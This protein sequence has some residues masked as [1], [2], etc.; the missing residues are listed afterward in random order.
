[1]LM[2]LE[3]N[4]HS[5]AKTQNMKYV[6]LISS[7][8]LLSY[9]LI[10][11]VS[12]NKFVESKV[13]S[14]GI[15]GMKTLDT[16]VII[17]EIDVGVVLKKWQSEKISK[18]AEP[19]IVDISPFEQGLWETNGNQRIN[20]IKITAKKAN[21]I[22]VYFDKLKLSN[23]AELYI[24]NLDG[25]VI[26]GP[27]T[28]KE[29]IEKNILWGSNVFGGSTIILEFKT[30]IAEEKSN[31]LHIRK[32]LYGINPK[33]S[34][35]NKDSIMGPGFGL[36]SSC[37]I[38]V[39]CIPG[40]EQERR[41][42]AQVV[43]EGGG[44]CSAALIMNTCNTNRPY[45]LTANHCIFQN[46][47]L[48]NTNNSTFEFLWFSSACT[49]TTNTTSTLLFNGAVIRAR[50]EQS[51][52]ALLELNQTIPTNANLTLLGWSRSTTPPSSSVGIHHPLGDIMKISIENNPA[53]IGNVRTFANTA[54]RVVWDQG[55]AEGGSSGSPLFDINHRVVGQLFSNTQPSSPP[56]N[57]PTGGT[58]YG[59]FDI[60][61]AGGGTNSTR[62]SNWLDPS[63]SGVMTTNTTNVSAL[64]QSIGDLGMSIF[65]PDYLCSSA[66]YKLHGVPVGSPVTWSVSNPNIATVTPSGYVTATWGGG[67]FILSASTNDNCGTPINVT[68][69]ISIGAPN[70]S[71]YK[72]IGAGTVYADAG[73][74]YSVS[75]LGVPSPVNITWIVPAGWTIMNGQGTENITI[76]TGST[77]GSVTILFDNVCGQQTGTYKTVVIGTGGPAPLSTDPSI[78]TL[79]VTPNPASSNVTVSLVT[80]TTK[81]NSGANAVITEIKIIDKMGSVRKRFAFNNRSASQLI[82]I[83]GLSLDTY[84][85]QAF[86]GTKWLSAKLLIVNN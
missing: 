66:I 71:S 70:I 42:V 54:W 7:Y 80:N 58:N 59:R 53:S 81:M 11:Q 79:A 49:P 35:S 39:T 55:T 29:N 3:L 26:T 40:W 72:V 13:S 60:S 21:S 16:E 43:D 64:F 50:W 74:Y 18:F 67:I 23:N 78:T 20:R 86:T 5:H 45:I 56:C 51:D 8:L 62:L 61:W 44:W 33:L 73:Y 1:M 27:I 30:P 2:A 10:A 34:F 32:I 9:N 85:I 4:I 15:T 22:A 84:V 6:I 12:I 38:N 46:G 37:N 68:K 63:N 47:N 52:F 75:S 36:S 69:T 76:W 14:H 25:T 48:I 41:A 19:I 82:D 24:Y 28:K 77:G 83:S 31:E 17:P 57:Q 65:G